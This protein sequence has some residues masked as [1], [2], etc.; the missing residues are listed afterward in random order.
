M[1]HDT[2]RSP[3]SMLRHRNPAFVEVSPGSSIINDNKGDVMSVIH[4]DIPIT[5][6]PENPDNT[7]FHL[8]RMILDNRCT[9][10]TTLINQCI[11]YLR[12]TNKRVADADPVD[13]MPVLQPRA[14]LVRRVRLD[15]GL[16]SEYTQE[17]Q[18]HFP[19]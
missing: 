11:L 10:P 6:I 4:D 9:S 12:T 5:I 15:Q 7:T 2:K 19:A 18:G 17:W 14:A 13:A 3:D 1:V 8:K 16:Y